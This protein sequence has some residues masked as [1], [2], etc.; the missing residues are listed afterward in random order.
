MK[1]ERRR[2]KNKWEKFKFYFS[3]ERY[4]RIK[5]GYQVYLDILKRHP[6]EYKNFT[7]ISL[8]KYIWLG[9]TEPIKKWLKGLKWKILPKLR[10]TINNIKD[11]RII[12]DNTKFEIID[13]EN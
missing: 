2:E 4:K 1:I 5:I 10:R 7:P 11:L 6:D 8:Y 13:G 3:K 12:T 9:E